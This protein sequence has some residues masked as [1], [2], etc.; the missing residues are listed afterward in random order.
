MAC[1]PAEVEFH[2]AFVLGLE[3]AKFEI[4]S[5]KAFQIAVIEEKVK[6]EVVG[7][8][9][10]SLLAGKESEAVAKFQEECLEFRKMAF[11]RSFSR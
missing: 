3:V 6:V 4:N 5:D 1:K 11:S 10:D 7:I 8:D 2:L 9:L